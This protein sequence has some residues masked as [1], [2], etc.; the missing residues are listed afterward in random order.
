MKKRIGLIVLLAGL[1]A[2]ASACQN[3][4]S[5]PV[6]PQTAEIPETMP[7]NI[8]SGQ[9]GIDD[10][11]L[12]AT[13][14]DLWNGG[15][16]GPSLMVEGTINRN[17]GGSLTFA[18][19]A[20]YPEYQVRL[21]LGADDVI[22]GS[23]GGPDDIF[24]S[25]AIPLVGEPDGVISYEFFPTGIRFD[26]G[27]DVTLCLPPWV[28]VPP[29]SIVVDLDYKLVFIEE[30][31]HET[32]RHYIVSDKYSS[33]PQAVLDDMVGPWTDVEKMTEINY[34]I[35]HFSRWGVTS[36]TDDGTD[37][38]SVPMTFEQLLS[39]AIGSGCW[40]MY[41]TGGAGD[42]PPALPLIR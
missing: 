37:G 9:T 31:W 22:P 24:F 26:D 6:A 20:G 17:T 27:I 1:I 13:L 11:H 7:N 19:F 42:D 14:E 32:Q 3:G 25:I 8:T 38:S 28:D 33:K 16:G 34:K 5:V 21:S 30:D 4:S 41:P 36:G 40:T 18:P 12:H 35:K 2:L 10:P 29:D 39:T 15:S 23:Y